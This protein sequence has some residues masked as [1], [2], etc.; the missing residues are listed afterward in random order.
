L[1]IYLQRK[2]CGQTLKELGKDYGIINYCTVSSA[3]ERVKA[4][5]LNDQKLSI[6]VAKIESKLQKGQEKI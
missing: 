4:R 1:Q 5:L 2:Y 3:Y 6:T